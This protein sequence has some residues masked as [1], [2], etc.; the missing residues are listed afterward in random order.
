MLFSASTFRGW[1][2]AAPATQLKR[3]EPLAPLLAHGLDTSNGISFNVGGVRRS[4]VS[5]G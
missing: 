4:L 3:G 1:Q 5:P 2:Q